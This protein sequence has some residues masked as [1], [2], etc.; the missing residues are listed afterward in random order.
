[1][2]SV[3]VAALAAAVLAAGCVSTHYRPPQQVSMPS[4]Q[5]R[6]IVRRFV[7]RW[8]QP[9]SGPVFKISTLEAIEDKG[10]ALRM[11]VSDFYSKNA[12]NYYCPYFEMRPEI[13]TM[14]PTHA[15]FFGGGCPWGLTF[16]QSDLEGAK[17]FTQALVALAA[18]PLSLDPLD[19]SSFKQLVLKYRGSSEPPTEDA[20]KHLIRAEAAVRER[21]LAEGA[22]EYRRALERAPWH[23]DAYFNLALI[24]AETGQ[25]DH[26]VLEMRKY[27]ALVPDAEDAR[28]AKD[29]IYEWGGD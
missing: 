13:R 7:Q 19:D 2:K 14:G 25:R 24:L 12:K 9:V 1:M 3:S 26:A 20:R 15:V 5:A 21:R 29:K 10:S 6:E 18:A 27:L 11:R 4:R 28:A 22:E 16:A 8:R 23:S 17:A